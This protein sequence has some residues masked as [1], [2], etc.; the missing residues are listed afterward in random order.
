MDIEVNIKLDAKSLNGFLLYHNYVRPG[1][2]IGLLVSVAA[3]IMLVWKWDS[4]TMVQKGILVVLALLFTVLQPLILIS[5]GKRQLQL[6]TFQQPFHYRFTKEGV[7]IRQKEQEQ[8]FAWKNVRKII[9]RKEAVYVYT[10]AVAAFILPKNQCEDCF[11]D[12][13]SM[14]KEQRKR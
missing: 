8:T 14:M 7:V 4:W 2:I 5:K 13:V 12:L 11:A 6:E 3:L 9:Y 10:S 1:G